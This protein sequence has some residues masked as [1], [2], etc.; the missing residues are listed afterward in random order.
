VSEVRLVIRDAQREISGE[1][2]GS[3]AECVVAALSAEP[4]TIDELGLALER[5]VAPR[6]EGHFGLFRPGVN[7]QAGDAGVV[8]IDLAARLVACESTYFDPG[9]E[10]YVAYHDGQGATDVDV[11][12]HLSEDWEFT[13]DLD[14][15]RQRAERRR[16]ARLEMPPLDARAV[17]YGRPMLEF[18]A[19]ECPAAFGGRPEAAGP[20]SPGRQD[21][22]DDLVRQIHVK[23]MMT[24]RADLRGSA[25]RDVMLARR[26]FVD[27]DLQDRAEQWSRTLQPPRPLDPGSAAYRFS[28][29]GTHEIVTYYQLVRDLMWSCRRRAAERPAAIG[30]PAERRVADLTSHLAGMLDEMLDRPDPEFGNRTARGIIHN[31]RIRLPEASCGEDIVD[32]DCPLCQLQADMP[33]PGFWHLDGSEMDDDFA[34]SFHHTRAEFD[35]ENRRDEEFNRRWKAEQAEQERLGVKSPTAGWLDPDCA[36][37]ATFAEGGASDS[38]QFMRLF[39]IGSQLC[40]ITAALKYSTAERA[41]IDRLGRDYGNLREVVQGQ[42]GLAA[43]SLIQPVLERFYESLDAVVA[44]CPDLQAQCAA[45]QERLGRFVDLPNID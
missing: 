43:E 9:R 15:W 2:H 24:A 6:R 1:A 30:D 11:R 14:S 32:P 3:L 38:Y 39:S 19:R 28:G 45:F 21:E 4:E 26:K 42:D 27:W 29:F 33:Q 35:E 16:R 25:P 13:E 36:W 12:Y 37:D 7:E 22:E 40:R 31:E 44:A 17:L 34:F 18:I 5:F 41:L 20:D 10:G 23:W 8:I